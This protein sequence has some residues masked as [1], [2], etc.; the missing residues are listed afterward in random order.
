[1]PESEKSRSGGR[2]TFG[3]YLVRLVFAL[4][5]VL[6]TYNP[7]DY[8]Y[9]NWFI[10]SMHAD[11]L[12]AIHFF[13]GVVLLIGW[14]ILL[15]ATFTALGPVGLVLG[16]ALFGTAVWLLFDIGVLRGS[17]VSFYTWV[18]LVALSA[19]LALGMC[20]SHVWRALTGQYA[21]DEIDD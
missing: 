19:F 1:M 8:S 18:A 13:I 10:D 12:G 15:R 4:L 21:V 16:V 5:A 6:A 9:V 20:W 2:F 3:D 14:A 17:G 7:S 11:G